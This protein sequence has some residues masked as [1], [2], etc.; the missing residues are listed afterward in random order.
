M[1]NN[2]HN[3]GTAFSHINTF[4]LAL[5]FLAL[6]SVCKLS[7]PC[8]LP[9]AFTRKKSYTGKTQNSF[10]A[11]S[12]AFKAPLLC[13]FPTVRDYR[14]LLWEHTALQDS[15]IAWLCCTEGSLRLSD[16]WILT[17]MEKSISILDSVSCWVWFRASL[18]AL[19]Q[20]QGWMWLIMLRGTTECEKK[21]H[22]PPCKRQALPTKVTDCSRVQTVSMKAGRK[23]VAL[24]TLRAENV[25]PFV[26]AY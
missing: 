23:G 3:A 16:Y 4:Q 10:S 25:L 9:N 14:W 15:V 1:T 26:K 2:P 20:H 6:F 19:K 18:Q 11:F 17:R 22:W 21:N 12:E 13:R 24:N 5:L 7:P 8:L